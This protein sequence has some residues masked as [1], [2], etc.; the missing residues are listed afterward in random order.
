MA[1]FE[2]NKPKLVNWKGTG[3]IY[4]VSFREENGKWKSI[5]ARKKSDAKEK[6]EIKKS[7]LS[8]GIGSNSKKTF[9]EVGQAAIDDKSEMV[10]KKDGLR[11]QSLENHKRHFKNHLV[12]FF[13]DRRIGSITTADVNKFIK[14]YKE[15]EYSAK[16][17]RHFVSTLNLICKY[18][19][20]KGELF[21]NPC[22]RDR[23]EAVRGSM[24]ERK[25]YQPDEISRMLAQNMTLQ[26]RCIIWVASHTGLAANELQGLQWR[27]IDLYAGSL[28][29]ERTGFRYAVQN[30][31]K[32]EFRKRTLP[33]PSEAISLL[34]EWQ[35]K[36]HT[37]VWV[38]PT[39]D[40]K[41]G[42]Q[43]AWRKL[44]AT[45]CKHAKVE[46]KSLGG[47]RKYFNTQQKLAG[48]PDPVRKMRMGHSKM[49][50]TSEV[51]YTDVDKK[52]AE[53]ASDVEKMAAQHTA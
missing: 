32:T 47:F 42:E 9:A 37:T 48:V 14:C 19:L 10:N 26:T 30:E 46:N 51:H 3:K 4:R 44:I 7:Q 13:K 23:R 35:L 49:S 27:D 41:M 52:L 31:T 25:G 2:I 33:L 45:V 28:T 15:K 1:T 53:S 11:P 8:N 16:S 50:N 24:K 40:G 43:N 39:I 36:S 17:I 29:V 20:D 12:K 18:A 6:Y 34:R 5:Y 38:F 22:N 21:T